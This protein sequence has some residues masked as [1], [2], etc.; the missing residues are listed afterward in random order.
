MM[1][2]QAWI[3]RLSLVPHPEGGHYRETYRAA[4]QVR[5]EAAPDNAPATEPTASCTSIHYLLQ[6][7]D[8]SGFHRIAYPELWYHHDGEPLTIH[9]IDAAGEYR[10][11]TLGKGEGQHLSLVVEP[12][13]WFAAELLPASAGTSF[14]NRFALVSCAVAPAFD[15]AKFEMVRRDAM[16]VQYPRHAE[17]LR[18]LC[19]E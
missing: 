9:E 4:F 17:V 6:D 3:T 13:V 12:G 15:F 16:I 19:R 1:T 7:A 14:S 8:Y 2:T 18:R 11:R 5:P 10:A